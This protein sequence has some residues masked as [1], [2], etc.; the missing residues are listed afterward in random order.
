[1]LIQHNHHTHYPT[2]SI[3]C[4][5]MNLASKQAQIRNR[6]PEVWL[7]RDHHPAHERSE[8]TSELIFHTHPHNDASSYC[9]WFHRLTNVLRNR[10]LDLFQQNANTQNFD[11]QMLCAG[12]R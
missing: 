9:A 4:P 7:R 12:S 10:F 3:F 11:L 1:M 2:P 5:K 8:K 6:F